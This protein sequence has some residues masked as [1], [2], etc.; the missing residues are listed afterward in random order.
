[1]RARILSPLVLAAVL[2]AGGVTALEIV[3]A[4][5]AAPA[6]PATP[7]TASMS[8]LGAASG[9]EARMAQEIA[10]HINRERSAR[11]LRTLAFDAGASGTTYGIAR[12]NADTGCRSCH[13]SNLPPY[14]GEVAYSSGTGGRA[15]S[16]TVAWMG[17][18]GH[19]RF[20]L[21][22]GVTRIAV[23]VAC[24]GDGHYEA[25][26]R[27]WTTSLTA[28]DDGR[29]A[30]TSSGSGSSCGSSGA[31]PP[32][33]PPPPPGPAP[34]PAPSAA[35]PAAPRPPSAPRAP[36][37]T[38]TT[39]PVADNARVEALMEA[40]EPTLVHL[41]ARPGAR[42]LE[43][44]RVERYFPPAP[45]DHAPVRPALVVLGSLVL[46]PGIVAARRR[47]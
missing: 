13:G 8:S 42:P 3:T 21:D 35:G 6:A 44:R 41:G 18:S 20:L 19:R 39:V 23:G 40:L 37:P 28:N 43:P 38:T 10:A 33:P 26:A 27:V 22:T 14:T 5:P 11:G 29:P 45:P 24:A 1:M 31:P 7:R 2:V 15:G 46:V 34:A 16:A 32:P 12:H 17:S 25:I 47:R 30:V 9:V 4:T 36:A